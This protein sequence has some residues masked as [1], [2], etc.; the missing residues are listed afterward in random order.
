MC[1]AVTSPLLCDGVSRIA[2]YEIYELNLAS[3]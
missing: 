2:V 1:D 3:V